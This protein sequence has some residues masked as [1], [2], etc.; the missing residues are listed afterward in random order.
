MFKKEEE[1]NYAQ[2]VETIIGPSIKVKGNF[3]GEGNIIIEGSL[4]G[5]LKT[6]KNLYVGDNAKITADIEAKDAR[7]GGEVIGNISVA[8]N[9]EISG[10]AKV[11]GDVRAKTIS[12]AKG[13]IFN[14]NCSM[15]NIQKN[16][17]TQTPVIE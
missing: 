9:L 17:D 3:H 14:G 4:E 13:A 2:E 11:S 1:K 8:G 10:S 12:I 5:S 7:I 16:P 15:S 6:T